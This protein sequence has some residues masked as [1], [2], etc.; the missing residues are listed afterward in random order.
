[1][2]KAKKA[3]Q[4]KPQKRD[5]KWANIIFLAIGV[6]VALSMIITSVISTTATPVVVTPT[7]LPALVTPAP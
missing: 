5:I 1:M 4:K 2:A 7:P 3:P 6:V